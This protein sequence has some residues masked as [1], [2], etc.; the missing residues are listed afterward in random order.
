MSA[1]ASELDPVNFS[2]E[3]FPSYVSF[4]SVSE[5]GT[6][7]TSMVKKGQKERKV[8]N[9]EVLTEVLYYADAE[10]NTKSKKK[11][12]EIQVDKLINIG[13]LGDNEEEG[14]YDEDERIAQ[15]LIQPKVEFDEEAL[16]NWLQSI[17]PKVSQILEM[18][19]KSKTFDTYEVFWEEERGEI[20]LWH[21]LSTNFDF[22]E[23]NKATQKALN[24]MKGSNNTSMST[25]K[26]EDDDWG[27]RSTP[28]EGGRQ[29]GG[30]SDDHYQAV[31]VAWSCN[32]A[33]I[34]VAYGKTN[35][36]AWCEHHSSVSTWGIFRREFDAKKPNQTIEVSN[37]VTTIEFHPSD[38]VI[39]AGGTMNGEIY[40]WNIDS[41]RDE[42]DPQ[43]CNSE[44]DEYYH[45]EAVTKLIW[46]KYESLTSM[47]F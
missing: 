35:H 27:G 15:K 5:V 12:V 13:A 6:D 19:N 24:Q 44:I 39:L 16:C 26:D 8:K 43:I 7:D 10:T 33:T 34:A 17:Y 41:E 32:G 45:R 11:D 22:K 25:Q 28:S 21:K 1:P 18:N 31:S 4:N 47:Q 40:L 30:V 38:P 2:D 9:A 42:K 36:E 29:K 23:A 20:E 3:V 14:Y 37:C 46:I